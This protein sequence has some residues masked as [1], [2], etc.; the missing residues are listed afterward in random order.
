MGE[1]P[2]RGANKHIELFIDFYWHSCIYTSVP[3]STPGS[4]SVCKFSLKHK[5]PNL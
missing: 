1:C 5:Q 2:S 3:D 4:N